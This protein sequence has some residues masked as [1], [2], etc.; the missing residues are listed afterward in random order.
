[1]KRCSPKP[2]VLKLGDLPDKLEGGYISIPQFQHQFV[3]DIDDCAKLLDSVFKGVGASKVFDAAHEIKKEISCEFITQAFIK[4]Y[5]LA[6]RKMNDA[7]NGKDGKQVA[8]H[9]FFDRKIGA[10]MSC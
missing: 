5:V 6:L 3:W 4:A 9:Q 7:P 10:V 8:F 2:D 1:M